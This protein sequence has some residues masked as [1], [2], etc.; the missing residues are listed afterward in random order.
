MRSLNNRY[1]KTSIKLP[2]HL[3]SLETDVEKL[4][5]SHVE[6]GSITFTLRMRNTTAEAAYD[7]NRAALRAYLED[8]QAVGEGQAT[9]DLGTLLALPGV[10][11]PKEFDEDVRQREWHVIERLALEAIE[12]LIAMR[13]REGEALRE[14]LLKHTSGLGEHLDALATLAP[15][16]VEEYH[17]RLRQRVSNLVGDAQLE[18]DK[19]AL[20]REVALFAERCDISEEISRVRSH[21]DQFIALCDSREPAGRKLEF[22]AQELLREANTIGSKANDSEIARHVVE[23]KGLIDRLKEQVQNAE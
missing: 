4:L 15:T 3:Q 11:Q 2:E 1:F 12:K 9:V 16:V 10:C 19:D 7:I 6:R 5:R 22:L 17:K 20:A 21:L 23:I 8:V 18:L 13:Q 14:D